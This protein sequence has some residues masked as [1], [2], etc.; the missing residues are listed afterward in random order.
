MTLNIQS[1][2]T[3]LTPSLLVAA[4]AIL[5]ACATGPARP[6]VPISTGDPRMDPDADA[7]HGAPT[8]VVDAGDTDPDD[9]GKV[10]DGSGDGGFTPAHM[11]GRDLKR[12]AILLPLSHPTNRNV[13]IEAQSMLAGAELALFEFG[14]DDF[15]LLPFD[16]NGKVSVARDA[17]RQALEDGAD[18]IIGPLYAANV[19]A[20]SE[21]VRRENVPVVAFSNT[22]QAANGGALLISITVEEEVSRIVEYAARTGIDSFA[23]FG[24]QSDYGRRAEMALRLAAARN[25]GQVIATSFYDPRGE[26]PDIEAQYVASA[27]NEAARDRPGRVAVLIPER[28]VKL[29]SVAPLLAVHGVDIRYVKLLGTGLWNDPS[30]WREPTLVGGVF[31]APGLDDVAG[32]NETYSRNYG[33]APKKLASLG[34]DA[35]ALAVSLAN[36]GELD[37]RGV[38]SPDGFIGVNGLFRF[39]Y[40]GTAERGLAVVEIKSDGLAE[41]EPGARTFEPS[42]F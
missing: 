29:R 5:S 17:A 32:F 41:L 42:G 34:Y 28:S 26:A 38:T 36:A 8:D 1:R 23:F 40:D 2:L 31:A 11:Q 10:K 33:R 22:P 37:R 7:G 13:S 18:I 16:T 4:F 39:R 25:G 27:V 35:T 12:A 24:P 30:I 14:G 9:P 6:P 15:L 21:I 20:V 19:E 3:G